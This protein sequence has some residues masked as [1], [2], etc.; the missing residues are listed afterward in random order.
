MDTLKKVKIMYN[1]IN[2]TRSVNTNKLQKCMYELLHENSGHII[3][4]LKELQW[5]QQLL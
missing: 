1:E 4:S 2:M 3:D 5:L